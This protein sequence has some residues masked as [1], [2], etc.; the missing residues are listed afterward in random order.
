MRGRLQLALMVM[1]LSVLMASTARAEGVKSSVPILQGRIERSN[2]QRSDR[3]QP[4]TT[5]N[6]QRLS[7]IELPATSVKDLLSQSS[8]PN[9]SSPIQI[10]AVRAVPTEQGVEVILETPFGEQLQITN[11]SSG[12]NYIADIPNAQL[13]L[14]SGDAFTFRSEKP[15]DGVTEITVT[16]LDANTLRVTVTG[17]TALPTVELFDSDAGLIV[18]VVTAT[19]PTPPTSETP[20]GDDSIAIVVTGEQDEGYNPSSASTATRTDTPLRDIPQSITVVPRQVLEDRNVRTVTEAVE[21]VP[22]VVEGGSIYGAPGLNNRIIR[23]FSQGF[24]DGGGNL[25]NGAR[26][27]GFYG[28]RPIETVEQVEVLRGPA[29]VLFGAVE[30]GGVINVITRQPL[31]EPYYNLRF[32]AGNYGFYQPSIDLSGPLTDDDTLLYRFIAAYQGEESYQDFV[33]ESLIT[34]APSI[35]LNLGDQTSVNLYYEHIDFTGDPYFVNAAPLLSDDNLLPRSLYPGYPDFASI[36]ITTH[37]F[38]YVLNHEFSGDWQVRNNLAVTLNDFDH[39]SVF[40]TGLEDDRFLTVAIEEVDFTFTN[41][42]GLIELLGNF[43]TGSI[44]HQVLIGF[45]VNRYVQNLKTG[46][47]EQQ[48]FLF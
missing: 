20:Q 8:T 25:R 42:F 7:E 47:L 6:I 5:T 21:T 2:T 16:N 45:D 19:S 15:V 4:I 22:G 40:P 27:G 9:V 12:N 1:A 29:S 30:P 24:A 10:T 13:R 18:G 43:D 41:Y 39:N 28:V 11:R 36:D 3:N 35:T 26:D 48:I 17:E 31:S 32:E 33:E 14:P 37:R 34:I 23:G 44:S 38:G 46:L